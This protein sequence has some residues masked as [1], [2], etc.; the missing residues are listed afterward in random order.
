MSPR[1]DRA[2]VLNSYIRRVG[3][4]LG[5]KDWALWTENC[6]EPVDW[7]MECVITPNRKR[8]KIR[9]AAAFWED[10]TEDQRISVIHELIH[11]QMDGI[12]RPIS[13]Y[14]YDNRLLSYEAY[15][16]LHDA[17]ARELE[18]GVDGLA[19]AI[20]PFFPFFPLLD[21]EAPNE[22]EEAD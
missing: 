21:R 7:K 4:A 12:L 11:C 18:L 5:L 19:V 22:K 1:R 13:Q 14:V 16:L 9:V 8:A 3:N 10:G 6:P 20:A 15:G 2:A 17:V